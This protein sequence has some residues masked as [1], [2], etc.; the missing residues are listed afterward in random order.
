MILSG[1]FTQRNVGAHSHLE[2]DLESYCIMN[3]NVADR[4]LELSILYFQTDLCTI[5]V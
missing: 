2:T 4:P 5:V 3:Y 1:R